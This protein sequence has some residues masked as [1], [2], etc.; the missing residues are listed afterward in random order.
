VLDIYMYSH[1]SCT[2]AIAKQWQEVL[3]ANNLKE[4]ELAGRYS[5]VLHLV[6]AADGAPDHYSNANNTARTESAEEA[7]ALDRRIQSAWGQHPSVARVVVDNSTDFAGKIARSVDA[8]LACVEKAEAKP[9]ASGSNLVGSQA[10]ETP[11]DLGSAEVM[12][13]PDTPPPPVQAMPPTAVDGNGK[14]KGKGGP[15]LRLPGKG[16]GNGGGKGSKGSW[17]E[18]VGQ[19]GDAAV[20]AISAAAPGLKVMKVPEGAM[21]TMDH[22]LDRVRVYVGTDGKVVR[23]P[24]LG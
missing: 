7:V 24:K 6:T 13:Q 2:I 22:R 20:S 10:T 16:K 23:P 18:L 19:T 17:P 4:S 11:K 5:M 21:V 15:L 9:A 3:S 8:V 12:Q 1:C 14:G